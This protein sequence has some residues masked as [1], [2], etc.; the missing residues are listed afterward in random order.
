MDLGSF[1]AVGGVGSVLRSE[2]GVTVAVGDERLRIEF[3]RPD[4]ARLSL[5]RAARFEDRP[6]VATAF[7]WPRPVEFELA[8][9]SASVVIETGS[10]RLTVARPELALVA[11]RSDGTPIFESARDANG[12]S[13]AYV[14]LNDAFALARTRS[15]SDALFGLGQRTG[16]LERSGRRFLMW[17]VDVLAPGVLRTNRLDVPNPDESGESTSFDPYYSST[18]FFQHARRTTVGGLE[19]L[20]ASGFFF[21]NGWPAEFDF[22]DE[23]ALFVRFLGGAYTEYVFSGPE[24]SS[25]LEAYTFVTGRPHVPPLWSLGHHQCRWHDYTDEEL[26]R[27]GEEYRARNIPCDALWLDIGHMDGNRVFT[28]HP[29]RFPKPAETFETLAARGF[30]TVTIVDPGVKIENGFA[31]FDAAKERGLFAKTRAGTIY[32]GLVWPGRT[33][34]PDFVQER[35]RSFWSELVARH[36]AHGVAGIW[37]DMNEPAT[38]PIEPFAMRFDRDGADDPHERWHNQYALFMAFATRE[39]LA[40]ARPGERPFVLTRAGFAGM[41]RVAAQWLGDHSATFSHLRMGVAMALGMGLSG[42]PFVG[43]DVPGFAGTAEPELAAR[44]FSYAALT[45]FCRC[46]HQLGTG[47]HYPWSFGPD[48]ERVAR[49]ALELR[50]RLLPY[51][52]TAFRISAETGAPIQRPLVFEFQDDPRTPAID[53]EFMLGDALLVSPILDPGERSRSTYLPGESFVDWHTKRAVAGGTDVVSAAPLDRCPMYVRGGAVIPMIAE[54]FPTTMSF[55]PE[56]IELHAFVPDDD[57]RRTSVLYEDDGRTFAFAGGAFFFT[58]IEL[59][60]RGGELRLDASVTGAGFAEFRRRRFRV[61]FVNAVPREIRVNGERFPIVEDGVIFDN[62][63]QPF[64]LTAT[65]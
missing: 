54:A 24:L 52:Y 22:R 36:A 53:D 5:S 46:H 3:L 59:E 31:V 63:G 6:T 13:L 26:V 44:W 51:L 1:S 35:T 47:D 8:E 32:E 18:P 43:G 21:D 64:H 41:Q 45:P 38:G 61:V 28:F 11:E 58:S 48:V 49:S 39:G 30:R 23:R 42:Q 16:L 17:N 12:R 14:V 40:R 20:L 34:F 29:T 25:V 10:L 55:A 19:R 9:S 57:V 65:L 7:A 15:P 60:R 37:N 27:V 4:L 56:L 62:T 33:A 50:Y 2:R